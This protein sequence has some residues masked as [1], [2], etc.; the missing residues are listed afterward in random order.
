VKLEIVK[1]EATDDADHLAFSVEKF[2]SES[3]T[4]ELKHTVHNIE[5][6]REIAAEIERALTMLAL[7]QSE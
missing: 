3:A 4:V 6:W 7:E 5:S 1:I 2:D